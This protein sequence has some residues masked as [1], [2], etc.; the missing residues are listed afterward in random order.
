MT[1]P[2]LNSLSVLM[3]SLLRGTSG[4]LSARARFPFRRR[5]RPGG[6]PF[7]GAGRAAGRGAAELDY[8]LIVAV[9][10]IA[11]MVILRECND[12]TFIYF[13]QLALPVSL[14]IP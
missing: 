10:A 14:P 4:F 13:Q 6:W 9:F 3:V 12:M 7:R 8:V 5:R 2:G 1:S 11:M